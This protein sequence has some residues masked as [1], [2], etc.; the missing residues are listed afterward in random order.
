MIREARFQVSE[1]FRRKAKA[2]S[3]ALKA[4]RF[5]LIYGGALISALAAVFAQGWQWPLTDLQV[6]GVVG[7]AL[8]CL[9]GFFL[10]YIEESPEALHQAQIAIRDAEDFRDEYEEVAQ[11]AKGY[12]RASRR[13]TA[14][15]LAY[16]ASRGVLERAATTGLTDEIQIIRSCLAAMK[17]DLRISLGFELS[18]TWTICV[19]IT[20][21]P[22]TGQPSYLRCIA[23]DRTFDCDIT[24][25]R[26]WR[27]GVGVG[28]MTLARNS[29]VVAPDTLAPE[30]GSLFTLD[31]VNV[32]A[33]DR[34]RYRSLIGVPVQVGAGTRPYGVVIVTS[35]QPEHF[36]SDEVEGVAPEEGARALA[37][38]VALAVALC[39]NASSTKTDE[40][41]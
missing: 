35:D 21:T 29:E 5:G 25:A 39:R 13:L 10:I 11:F 3:G 17:R 6:I 38:V 16:S 15:Y 8:V 32:S 7:A 14:L 20:E 33:L 19:Y 4:V 37:G 36:G 22:E 30:A 23:H 28:G 18:H 40:V 9:G 31:D 12:E 2:M 1:A 27:E 24:K 26:L 34:D 41:V